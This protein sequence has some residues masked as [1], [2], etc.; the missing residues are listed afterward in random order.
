MAFQPVA[1]QR[2]YQGVVEQLMEY[3]RSG[4]IRPGERF[5]SEREL[6]LDLGVSRGILREAFRVLEARG[7]IESRPGGGRF[8][9]Q[10]NLA[11]FLDKEGNFRILEKALLL[12]VLE[13]RQVIELKMVLLATER[14]TEEDLVYL[15]EVLENF[16]TSQFHSAEKEDRD[17]DFH[18]AI[19]RAAHNSI[20]QELVKFQMNLLKEHRQQTLLNPAHWA[21]LCLEHRQIL[22]SIKARDPEIAVQVM[23][24]H[25]EHLREAIAAIQ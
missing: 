3:I 19:A 5:P 21:K 11:N 2:L 8:L 13:V 17:L 6:E 22:E 4:A 15:E 12:D 9:L 24:K 23:E 20:L 16:F 7:I 25:L 10:P 1:R 14:A 18:L